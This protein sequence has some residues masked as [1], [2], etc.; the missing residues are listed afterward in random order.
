MFISSCT[1]TGLA[2]PRWFNEEVE[3]YAISA[4]HTKTFR[5]LCLCGF[6][7]RPR[8]TLN[9]EI[10]AERFGECVATTR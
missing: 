9:Y 10:P 2:T 7:E 4:C 3:V 8:K 1:F 6:N 5:P